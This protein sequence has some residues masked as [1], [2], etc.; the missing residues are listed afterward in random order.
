V[1]Q[2]PEH[3]AAAIDA[4]LQCVERQIH[5]LPADE[6]VEDAGWSFDLPDGWHV[7]IEAQPGARE[8]DGEQDRVCLSVSAGRWIARP[9]FTRYVQAP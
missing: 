5:D 3:I 1:R 9:I 2:L 4:K 7:V 6:L 8:Q